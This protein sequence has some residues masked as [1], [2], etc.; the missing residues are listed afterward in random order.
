MRRDLSEKGRAF[1][2]VGTLCV[3]TGAVWYASGAA[4]PLAHLA[5]GFLFGLGV[6]LNTASW[7]VGRPRPSP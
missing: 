6:T 5:S 1:L 2:V 4:S 7:F 3:S